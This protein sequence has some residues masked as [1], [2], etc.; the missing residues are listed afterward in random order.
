MKPK[1]LL[2]HSGGTIGM[3][4]SAE[5]Y[6]PMPSFLP[7]LQAELA[8]LDALYQIHFLELSPLMD[9]ANL[10]ARD[11]QHLARLLIAH[12]E[13]YDGFVLLHGTDTLAYSASA[14]SFLLGPIN[15]PV[16]LTGS[17]IPLL[18]PRSDAHQ[19]LLEALMLASRPEL[20]EVVICFHQRI[21]RGNRSRKVHS[22]A[23]AAFDSP[24]FPWLG[25]MQIE[26]QL[27]SSL[28]LPAAT[29][30]FVEVDLES[31]RV[32]QFSFFPGVEAE[33]LHA[34]I[35]ARPLDGL[36]LHTYG[37]GNI[38]QGNQDLVRVLEAAQA[39]GITLVN[40]T[41]CAQGAV[42]QQAYAAGSLL[43]RIGVL[44]AQEMTPE[45][46]F[47]KLTYL[48]ARDL[49]GSELAQAFTLPLRGEV[50]LSE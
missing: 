47:T 25:E 1:I 31:V 11:W 36:V 21:L 19:H 29:P 10:Q 13:D 18:H 15:K 44:S 49:R 22:Q 8:H 5:G 27:E 46:A 17:Q 35:Q 28:L 23:M 26:L 3:Q 43:S 16:V 32:A 24:N 48:L 12:W 7:T 42:N 38:P 50:H 40:T 30:E 2:L 6:Q 14:L 33:Q 37:A 45:A 20:N 9:S 34:M 4:P 41:Q 39:Q